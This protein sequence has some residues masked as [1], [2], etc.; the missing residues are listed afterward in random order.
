MSNTRTVVIDNK[1]KW[2]TL[3]IDHEVDFYFDHTLFSS[4]AQAM[5]YYRMDDTSARERLY[6][7]NN[8]EQAKEESF[9]YT[10][11]ISKMWLNGPGNVI[12]SLTRARFDGDE[13]ARSLLL[14]TGSGKIVIYGDDL[15]LFMDK[16]SK[17]GLNTYGRILMQLRAWYRFMERVLGP[18]EMSDAGDIIIQR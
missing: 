8:L 17:Q 10:G 15:V 14:S 1:N 3:H 9:Q 7:C 4:V 13:N 12:Y 5:M 11:D 16:Q 18:E 6:N 2:Q